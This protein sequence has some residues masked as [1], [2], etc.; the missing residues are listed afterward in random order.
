[1]A[2]LRIIAQGRLSE[3]AG[4]TFLDLDKAV[5][6]IGVTDR[7]RKTIER[8]DPE[9]KKLYTAYTAGVN[10]CIKDPSCR[11]FEAWL[12]DKAFGIEEWTDQDNFS[13]ASLFYF[14]T[15]FDFEV[16]I[17]RSYF[18]ATFKESEDLKDFA[19][20]FFLL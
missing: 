18:D 4:G 11:T 13:V 20:Q 9:M 5:R 7:S 3:L 17:Q 16:E 2:K 10:A 15:A 8:M 1:M 6:I 14:L 12:L 19:D